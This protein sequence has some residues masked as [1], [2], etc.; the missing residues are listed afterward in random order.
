LKKSLKNRSTF[1]SLVFGLKNVDFY[2]NKQNGLAI[3]VAFMIICP[4]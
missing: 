2:E 3:V 4:S 1:S